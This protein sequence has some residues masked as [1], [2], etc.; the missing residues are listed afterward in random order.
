MELADRNVVVT[1]AASGIGRAFAER[2][3]EERPGMLV[4][5][6]LN[7][8]GAE[9]VAREV[10]GVAVHADVSREAD[11]QALVERARQEGGPIDVFYSNAGVPGPGGGPE[12]A[13]AEWELTWK[14]NVMAH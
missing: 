1:G 12:A 11:I 5:A 3:A 14:V 13:D 6:D 4:V 8:E 7:L 2:V 9:A 10:G